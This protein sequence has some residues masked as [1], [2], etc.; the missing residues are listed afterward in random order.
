MMHNGRCKELLGE[1]VSK[2][3][4]CS[5]NSVATAWSANDLD[6]G[7]L[8]FLR[9]LNDGVPCYACKGIPENVLSIQP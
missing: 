3:D 4:C 9:T 5:T 6:S 8:F 2:E 1:K 7:T